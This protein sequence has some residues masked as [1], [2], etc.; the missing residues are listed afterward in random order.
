M[1]V[2]DLL[3]NKVTNPG[4]FTAE[5]NLSFRKETTILCLIPD[6]QDHG[7]K[8]QTIPV[9]FAKLAQF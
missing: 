7:K 8:M 2:K 3:F 1:V 6:S 9:Q 5:F 4:G